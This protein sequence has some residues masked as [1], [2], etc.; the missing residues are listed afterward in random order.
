M[1]LIDKTFFIGEINLPL[2]A[3]SSASLNLFISK[4]EKEYL[5]AALGYSL[6]KAFDEGIAA[7]E[8]A[9]RFLAIK[10]G[11][12]YT[13]CRGVV[14]YWQG[15]VSGKV[16][17][18]ANYVYYWYTR[19]NATYTAPT[20][21]VKGKSD[22]ST[23]ADSFLKQMRAYNEMSRLTDQLHEFLKANAATYPEFDIRQTKPFGRITFI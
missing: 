14:D 12:E 17:P 20:G 6:W 19:D 3:D 18:I 9:D 7:E 22:N 5:Q 11:G 16:S 1:Q 10:N 21:E 2:S 13:N 23:N 8:P 4:Y 15:L